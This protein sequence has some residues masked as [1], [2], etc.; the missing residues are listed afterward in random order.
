MMPGAAA[1]AAGGTRHAPHGGVVAATAV[2]A[3]VGLVMVYS[4]TA[5]LA[6]E[7]TVPPHFARQLA[8]VVLGVAIALVAMQVPLAVW[9][10]LAIPIWTA[11]VLLLALTLAVGTEAKG[12]QRWLSLPG[13]GPTLQ[14]SELAR[15]AT[16]LATAA[17]LSGREAGARRAGSLPVSS[18]V[19]LLS[20]IPAALV[21]LEPDTKGAALLLLLVA[22]QLFVAGTPLRAFL[23]P[24]ACAAVAVG[25]AVALRPYVV[26]RILGFL[27][28][29][30]RA[31]DE[32]FQ[33]VQS[34]VAFGRGGL[35]GV[36]LGDGRQK[37]YYLPE[38]HTD[39]V[40]SVVAEELG[41]I[42]VLVVLAAFVGLLV[43]GVRIAGR[44]RSRFAFLLSFS[45]TAFVAVPAAINAAVVMGAVPPTG[46]T[47]PFVSYGRS[48]LL[49]SFAA[50][51]ILLGV[52]RREGA[53]EPAAA[54]AAPRPRGRR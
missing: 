34:F 6:L 31:D 42:G 4:A 29:W 17:V 51:G 13:I 37:L 10:R 38:A 36:G 1:A 25:A 22:L 41:L 14:P 33:L 44:T 47:L 35:S 2:L 49:A 43:A 54:P 46:L 15:W 3:C 53:N 23:V 7:A 16:V 5:H 28:P 45:M 52:S 20:V 8:G 27:D 21:F 50:I 12:A 18:L 24:A 19:L 30:A 39:F 11:C 32:G 48:S 26:D 9:H 40:L